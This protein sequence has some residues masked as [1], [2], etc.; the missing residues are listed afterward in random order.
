MTLE[1]DCL[2]PIAPLRD[3]YGTAERVAE[4]V[5]PSTYFRSR[6]IYYVDIESNR[7][8]YLARSWREGPSQVGGTIRWWTD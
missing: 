2:L 7:A 4:A 1:C 3:T 6:P 5:D 8:T